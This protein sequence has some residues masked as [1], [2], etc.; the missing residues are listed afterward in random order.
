MTKYKERKKK[1]ECPA[2]MCRLSI[3]LERLKKTTIN[4]SLDHRYPCKDS[5]QAPTEIKPGA[6]SLELICSVKM[7]A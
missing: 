3:C 4:L 2:L 6:L 5:N 1:W 7:C